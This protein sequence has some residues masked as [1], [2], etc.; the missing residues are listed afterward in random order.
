MK[1]ACN[2]LRNDTFQN[3]NNKFKGADQ[4]ADAQAGLRLCYL[5]NPEDRFSCVEALII[6]EFVGLISSLKFSLA[7]YHSFVFF[8]FVSLI[9]TE[10]F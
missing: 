4:T 7:V 5:Q 3:A 10:T 9:V 6:V 1:F 2:K 8:C